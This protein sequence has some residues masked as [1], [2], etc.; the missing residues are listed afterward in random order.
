LLL[1]LLIDYCR[2]R[3]LRELKAQMLVGNDRMQRLAQGQGF[4]SH[5]GA[6]AGVLDMRLDLKGSA[7]PRPSVSSSA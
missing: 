5:A 3:G 2:G 7:S 6:S 1:G 4:V